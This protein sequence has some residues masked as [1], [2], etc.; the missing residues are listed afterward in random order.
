MIYNYAYRSIKIKQ[1]KLFNKTKE[2]T[3]KNQSFNSYVYTEKGRIWGV[4]NLESLKK[5][6]SYFFQ[7]NEQKK[8]NIR[9][10]SNLYKISGIIIDL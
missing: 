6:L 8:D 10:N 1:Y 5:C 4:Q 2:N 7:Q 9:I 3:M